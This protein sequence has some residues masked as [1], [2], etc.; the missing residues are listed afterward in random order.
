[1]GPTLGEDRPIT[2]TLRLRSAF[3]VI[4]QDHL[5]AG[6]QAASAARLIVA[7]PNLRLPRPSVPRP[8]PAAALLRTGSCVKPSAVFLSTQSRSAHNPPGPRPCRLAA[9]QGAM[10]SSPALVSPLVSVP[11]TAC[12]RIPLVSLAHRIQRGE[13]QLLVHSAAMISLRRPSPPPG[14][15][16]ELASSAGVDRVRP[17]RLSPAGRLSVPM[18]GGSGCN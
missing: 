16:L 15:A 13:G 11:P 9:G 18:V 1:M 10:R 2:A 12:H 5:G 14:L 8:G 3:H 7:A 6:P 4:H 17:K